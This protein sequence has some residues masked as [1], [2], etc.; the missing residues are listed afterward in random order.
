LFIAVWATHG[1]SAGSE[2]SYAKQIISGKILRFAQDDNICFAQ[3]DNIRLA[4]D[5]TVA[6]CPRVS[7]GLHG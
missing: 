2:E 1:S 5:D 3:D 4:Q 6:L 7:A